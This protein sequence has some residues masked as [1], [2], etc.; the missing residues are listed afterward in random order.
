MKANDRTTPNDESVGKLISAVFANCV[1]EKAMVKS[2]CRFV[3]AVIGLGVLMPVISAGAQVRTAETVFVMSNNA[4]RNEVIA[5]QHELN[6]SYKRTDF[7]TFGRGSG[8][9]TILWNRKVRSSSAAIASCCLLR[10]QAAE[11]FRCFG[12]NMIRWHSLRRF[13][14]A[15]AS[16]FP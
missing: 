2:I 1:K 8:G 9:V 5:F 13:L 11:M 6:G 3:S 10:T 7:D 14:P 15:V 4:D 12:S 16:R